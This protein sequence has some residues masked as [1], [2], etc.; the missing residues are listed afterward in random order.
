MM[1]LSQAHP[2][3]W[4]LA[5]WIEFFLFCFFILP[6]VLIFVDSVIWGQFDFGEA[7][8]YSRGV[9]VGALFYKVFSE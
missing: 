2:R 7:T 6:F 1:K 3:I 5:K 9:F 8:S 4:Y